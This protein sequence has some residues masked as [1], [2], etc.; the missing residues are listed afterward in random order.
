MKEEGDKAPFYQFNVT[1]DLDKR[2]QALPW[3]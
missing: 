2:M 1:L 3:L